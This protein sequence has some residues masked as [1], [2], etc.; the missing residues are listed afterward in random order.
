MDLTS[1]V[2]SIESSH[3]LI[4]LGM[5]PKTA[6]YWVNAIDDRWDVRHD[7][8]ESDP[9]EKIRTFSFGELFFYYLTVADLGNRID[10]IIGR[11]NQRELCEDIAVSII[12][13][14]EKKKEESNV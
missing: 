2:C 4:N 8:F 9:R 12:E 6:F 7:D 13:F 10:S 5:K 1:E 14:L 11:S 3:K